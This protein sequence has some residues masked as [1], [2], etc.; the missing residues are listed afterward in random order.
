MIF[1]GDIER[2]FVK[3]GA[4]ATIPCI[5]AEQAASIKKLTWYKGDQKIVEVSIKREINLVDK[6]KKG[7]TTAVRCE[8]SK[9]QDQ[10]RLSCFFSSHLRDA[11]F[12]KTVRLRFSP[13]RSGVLLLPQVNCS[14]SLYDKHLCSKRPNFALLYTL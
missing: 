10:K 9:K 5:P 3:R 14:L 13:H 7:R 1:A 8:T 11:V 12:H 6:Q 2:I 4:N